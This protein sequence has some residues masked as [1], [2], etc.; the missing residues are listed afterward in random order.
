M[1]SQKTGRRAK[2]LA[3]RLAF[4]GVGTLVTF[5]LWTAGGLAATAQASVVIESFKTTAIESNTPAPPETLGKPAATGFVQNEPEGEN[6]SI[7]TS[8]GKVYAIEGSSET[9]YLD[10]ILKEP[11]VSDVGVG[12]TVTVYGT[13]T[14]SKVAA[15][16]VW[17]SSPHAGGHPNLSTS[18]MFKDP[19]EPEAAENVIFNAPQGVF[20]NPYAI[21]HCTAADFGLDQCPTNSQAGL[22]TVYA[23][24]E[25]NP[26]YL[27]GTA[28]LYDVEP[29][30]SET[31]LFAFIVPILNIPIT[32]PVAVRTAADEDYGLRF[33]VQDISQ[34][35]PL[36]G[37]NI[38]FWGFPSE[39]GVNGHD[40]ERF[41]KGAPGEPPNCPHTAS[42]D[43]IGG[44]GLKASIPAHPLTD[45]PTT[46]TGQPL[47]TSLAVQS[48]QDPQNL[49]EVKGIYP[50]TTGCGLEV[51]NPVLY[52]SP[53]TSQTDSASGLN[54]ELS[55]PQFLGFAASPSE[56]RSAT[57][58]LPPEFTVN[59][60]AADGQTA[61]TEAEANFNSE[62]PAECPD[63]SKIGRF[64]IETRGAT[65]TAR[66]ICIYRRTGSR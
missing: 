48:Y 19:G 63:T 47:V 40:Q 50:K 56:I 22:I 59:P 14:G 46:C 5:G 2:S 39:N 41:P 27:L 29:L 11:T 30:G 1:E 23:N 6:F 54:L 37:A 7:E 55:A 33:T 26:H 10:P 52:A 66:R 57:V 65:R 15:T 24:Y 13:V 53:T 4:V 64:L 8:E 3:R 62:G 25:G 49:S 16:A 32:I 34:V 35:T 21:T 36:S 42:A 38:I 31:G 44:A 58:T 45:N 51:F 18:F 43:C 28:P 60:D 12:D 17:I 20:G 61:C 9:A